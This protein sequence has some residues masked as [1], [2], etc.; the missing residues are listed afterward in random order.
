M[1][2]RPTKHE[3]RGTVLGAV[4]FK[5]IV[6]AASVGY[7]SAVSLGPLTAEL[8]ARDGTDI[9]D[10]EALSDQEMRHTAEDRMGCLHKSTLPDLLLVSLGRLRATTA[11]FGVGPLG[12]TLGYDGRKTALPCCRPASILSSKG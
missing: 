10:T 12:W 4:Q 2:K 1:Q 3:T 6:S 7:R 8:D 5:A 11:R 9:R